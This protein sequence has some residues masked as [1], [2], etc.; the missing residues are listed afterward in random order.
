MGKYWINID[1]PTR[2]YR[3]HTPDCK[4]VAKQVYEL[5][6]TEKK[7]IGSLGENGGWL[8]FDRPEAAEQDFRERYP[9]IV[10]VIEKL[11]RTHT[12]SQASLESS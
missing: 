10:L 12:I 11:Y 2:R 7:P 1:I 4:H 6:G 3:L 8:D 5:G 9:T